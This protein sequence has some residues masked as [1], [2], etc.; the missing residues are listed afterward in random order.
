MRCLGVILLGMSKRQFLLLPETSVSRWC[1]VA[2]G[3]KGLPSI[4]CLCQ[5]G[6]QSKATFALNPRVSGE[7]APSELIIS[8]HPPFFF[9]Q[10]L[11]TTQWDPGKPHV[12][13]P[14][15]NMNRVFPLPSLRMLKSLG[16]W[17]RKHTNLCLVEGEM[18]T[19]PISTEGL[20]ALPHS[21]LE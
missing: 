20:P 10:W 18:S 2:L 21:C 15:V 7:L 3:R 11:K 16:M 1:V 13:S 4:L 14:Q 17:I 8:N 9:P 6:H 5:L 19:Y 12:S